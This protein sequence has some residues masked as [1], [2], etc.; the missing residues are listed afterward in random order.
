[1]IEKLIITFWIT[2]CGFL[3]LS[4]VLFLVY[5]RP[6]VTLGDLMLHSNVFWYKNLKQL[7]RIDRSWIIYWTAVI[8]IVLFTVAVLLLLAYY[9]KPGT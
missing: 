2:G 7:V 1:M 3:A 8:G 6:E 4:G 5:K 9:S